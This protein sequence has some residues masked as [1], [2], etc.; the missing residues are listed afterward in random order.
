MFNLSLLAKT[1]L[2]KT[3]TSFPSLLISLSTDSRK[4]SADHL[5]VAL[6]GERFDAFDFIPQVLAQGCLWVVYEEGEGR[7]EKLEQWRKN[8]PK[9][10]LIPVSSSEKFLAQ[11]AKARMIQWKALGGLVIAITGSNGKTTHK[12]MLTHLLEATMPSKVHATRGNLNN[13]LGVP[14]TILDLQDEQQVAIVEMGTNHPGEIAPLC[15]IALPDAGIITNIGDSHLEFFKN[16]E[17]VFKEKSE[18]YHSIATREHSSRLFVHAAADSFLCRLPRAP[19]V[20]SFGEQAEA[21]IKVH[22]DAQSLTIFNHEIRNP[23]LIGKHNYSNLAACLILAAEL[24]GKM[25]AL[26]AAA[27]S[28]TPRANRSQV[29][30]IDGKNYYLDAYNAN[31]SSMMAAL[32]AVREAG[33]F[34][35]SQTLFI[36]GDMNELGEEAPSLHQKVG[37]FCKELGIEHIAFVGRYATYYQNGWGNSPCLTFASPDELKKEWP[38]LRQNYANFFIKGSRTLQLESL[39]AIT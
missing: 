1:T 37:S 23:H 34:D 6:K 17:G 31:P 16:R 3:Q 7:A 27:S 36:L 2:L 38:K 28:F 8:Y 4:A 9:A 26:I 35:E 14:F 33:L 15:D 29:V 30:A 11:L 24:F 21:N 32:Q 25:D 5:F 22:I 20:K 13:Q 12:E 18:L 10:C 19:W 39:T